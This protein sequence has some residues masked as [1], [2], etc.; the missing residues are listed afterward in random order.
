MKVYYAAPGDC[1]TYLR[2]LGVP[3]TDRT[4]PSAAEI[5]RC[6]AAIDQEAETAPPGRTGARSPS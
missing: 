6:T 5:A 2:A 3:T 1:A 4:R